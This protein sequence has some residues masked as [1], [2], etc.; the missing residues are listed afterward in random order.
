MRPDHEGKLIGL[1]GLL[2][3]MF[4]G[5]SAITNKRWPLVRTWVDLGFVVWEPSC[6]IAIGMHS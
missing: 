3:Q 5:S 4:G 2:L 6:W 1:L